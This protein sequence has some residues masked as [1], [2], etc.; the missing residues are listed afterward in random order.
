M[1]RRIQVCRV[2]WRPGLPDEGGDRCDYDD[3][4]NHDDEEDEDGDNRKE[5]NYNIFWYY[6]VDL[7]SRNWGNYDDQWFLDIN[8]GNDD[9]DEDGDDGEVN[10]EAIVRCVRSSLVS[11]ARTL[12]MSALLTQTALESW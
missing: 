5:D 4:Y 1:Q 6:V 2:Y 7:T 3:Q 9:D 10:N 8:Y 11:R 12:E